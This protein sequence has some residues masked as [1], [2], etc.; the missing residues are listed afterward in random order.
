MHTR[1]KMNLP[2]L[3]FTAINLMMGCF[4]IKEPG[5]NAVLKHCPQTWI[6]YIIFFS[7]F[8]VAD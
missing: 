4:P 8:W 5:V 6:F 1:S 2:S 3:L 7:E